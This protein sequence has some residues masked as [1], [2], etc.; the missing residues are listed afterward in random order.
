MTYQESYALIKE[1]MAVKTKDELQDKMGENMGRVDGTFFT[2]VDAVS[3]RLRA[4]GKADAANH[5]G[6]I[7]D[8]L[9]RLRFMI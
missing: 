5:L 8:A 6:Q 1:L 9:A 4:Q 7:G 3:A 2:V